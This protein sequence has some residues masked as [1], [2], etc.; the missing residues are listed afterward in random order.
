M[1]Y[2]DNRQLISGPDSNYLVNFVRLRRG[3]EEHIESGQMSFDMLPV[4]TYLLIKAD[5]NN[6]VVWHTSA[7]YIAMKFRKS[8]SHINRQLL[9]LERR[10]YIKRFGHRGRIAA[11][12]ILINKYLLFNGVLIDSDNSKSINE[13]AFTCVLKGELFGS[14]K[15]FKVD[16]TEFYL[17]SYKELKKLRIEEIKE[18]GKRKTAAGGNP[19]R[20]RGIVRLGDVVKYHVSPYQ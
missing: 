18:N 17:T 6:G 2:T 13:I 19:N 1:N 3:L 4:Y 20:H 9:N 16:L 11:Y 15:V 8:A 14:F 12:E 7:P 10:G 5:F